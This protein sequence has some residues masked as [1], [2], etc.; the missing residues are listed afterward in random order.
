MQTSLTRPV[1]AAAAVLAFGSSGFAQPAKDGAVRAAIEKQNAAFSA[2]FARG[3]AAALAAAYTDDAIVLPPDAEMV[4]GKAGI[5]ALWKGLISAGAKSLALT[6]V[7][8]QSSGAL[9]VE[10]GTGILK[11]QPSGAAEQTQSAKYVVVWKRQAD[12][13]WKLHRDMWNALPAAK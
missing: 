7:D 11:I 12:G 13:S 1:L 3:D 9:A 10:T 4:R 2:A 5:E 8:V 6:T